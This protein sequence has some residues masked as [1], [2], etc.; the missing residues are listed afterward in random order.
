M[1]ACANQKLKNVFHT[2]LLLMCLCQPYHT[3]FF[4]TGNVCSL[5]LGLWPSHITLSL[6]AL[7]LLVS[8]LSLAHYHLPVWKPLKKT[9]FSSRA[10][11]PSP[12]RPHPETYLFTLKWPNYLLC[13]EK[14][15]LSQRGSMIKTFRITS[16]SSHHESLDFYPINPRISSRNVLVY[17]IK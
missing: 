10:S 12:S 5:G 11:E 14:K 16:F 15:N 9:Y 1:E 4:P 6:L 8:L 7:Q 3:I 17:S 13:Q 2:S